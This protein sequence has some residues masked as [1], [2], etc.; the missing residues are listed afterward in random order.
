SL[1]SGEG[2]E[3]PAVTADVF[4]PLGVHRAVD[5]SGWTVTHIATG[6]AAARV[7]TKRTAVA[8]AKAIVESEV[9]LGVFEADS[10]DE[11]RARRGALSTVDERA[12]GDLLRG[13]PPAGDEVQPVVVV[14]TGEIRAGDLAR[15]VKGRHATGWLPVI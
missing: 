12:L 4:G 9:L 2:E 10:P 6:A 3:L 7:R 14:P 8:I 5:S 1:R 11:I 13:D 15:A